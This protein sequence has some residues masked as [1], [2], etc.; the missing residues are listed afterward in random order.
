LFPRIGL[1]AVRGVRR[2]A[3]TVAAGFGYAAAAFGWLVAR[4]ILFPIYRLVT[5]VRLRLDQLASPARNFFVT[6]LTNRYLFHAGVAALAVA[7]VWSNLQARQVR[8]Q[9]VGETSILYGLAADQSDR[10]A[11]EAGGPASLVRDSRHTGSASLVALANI[12][13]DYGNMDDAEIIPPA[14]PDTLAP[15]ALVPNAAESLEPAAMPR[16]DTETYVVKEGD[17]LASI[18]RR[19]GVT[20]GTILWA[21]SRTATQYIRPGD[22]L[23]IPPVSGVLVTV[24]KGDTLNAL[25]SKY[26]S[27][28]G[29]IVETNRLDAEK[30]LPI[31]AELILPGGEPP[32]VAVPRAIAQTTSRSAAQ[33]SQTPTQKP[34]DADASSASVGKLF[35]PTSGHV[36]TQYYG[37]RHTGLDVDGDLTSPLYASHDGIVTTSGWNS[38]G[39]GYQVVISGNGVMT[40][41]AHASK[42]FVKVGEAVKKGQT[43]AMMGSTGRSTGS[44][45]HYEVYIK[46]VRVNPLAYLK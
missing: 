43:I 31:G 32:A 23:R 40:R 45:L 2:A 33:P 22:A 10:S 41:Y 21:N 5:A 4:G 17:T 30:S 18:A 44:H 9:D 12:D 11:E 24:K 19:F 8:A 28:V 39:Y 14:M 35:W 16:T 29:E 25:A 20:V 36:I 13:F 42:L 34:P 3:F 15:T 46:G 6:F 27:S 1:H 37:W 26:G 38:G 7:T